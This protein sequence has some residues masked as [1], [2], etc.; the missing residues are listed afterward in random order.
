MKELVLRQKQSNS[1][2][3]HDIE[4]SNFERVIKFAK[5]CQYAVVIASYYGGK[6]YTTHKT[7]G[8]AIDAYYTGKY[9][10][11]GKQIINDEG[12]YQLF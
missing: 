6:G 9:K 3:I 4:S 8:N 5:G 11:Y 1:G 10:G 2:S 7:L 12:E